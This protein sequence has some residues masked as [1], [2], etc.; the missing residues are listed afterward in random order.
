MSGCRGLEERRGGRLRQVQPG[1]PRH[2]LR[3]RAR[4]PAAPVQRHRARRDPALNLIRDNACRA[5][6]ARRGDKPVH[7]SDEVLQHSKRAA[8][9]ATVL[10]ETSD[11]TGAYYDENGNRMLASKQVRDHEYS[12]RYVAETRA[13]LATLAVE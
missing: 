9:I 1:Q 8:R 3:V 10:T 11:T 7:P 13:L 2:G 5:P 6:G 4:V 12:D